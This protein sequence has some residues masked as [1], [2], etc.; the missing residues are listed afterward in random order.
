[1][2]ALKTA[3][4]VREKSHFIRQFF[5]VFYI[6]NSSCHDF[7]KSD[8]NMTPATDVPHRRR[9]PPRGPTASPPALPFLRHAS[10]LPPPTPRKEETAFPA[11][12]N[13]LAGWKQRFQLQKV[14]GQAGNSVSSSKKFADRQETAFPAPK[15][16]QTSRKQRFQLQKVCRQAGNSVSSSKKFADKLETVFL[17]SKSLRASRKQRF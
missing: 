6:S 15:S 17:A 14:C 5:T 8:G 2:T 11:P 1:M 3:G 12:K 16:L 9:H 7:M 13:L 10:R 4:K